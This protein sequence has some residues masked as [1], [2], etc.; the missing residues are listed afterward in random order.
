[1]E[2]TPCYQQAHSRV[3]VVLPHNLMLCCCAGVTNFNAI[4]SKKA[5]FSGPVY[6][7]LKKK[8]GNYQVCLYT[9]LV[10]LPCSAIGGK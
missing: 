8:D 5:T 7:T 9:W 3:L 4:A 10:F 6:T 2:V 1:M